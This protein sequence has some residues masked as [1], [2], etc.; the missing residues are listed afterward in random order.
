MSRLV[1]TSP[2]LVRQ[3]SSFGFTLIARGP[4]EWAWLYLFT[5]I[6]DWSTAGSF[7][8]LCPGERETE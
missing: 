1:F 8:D 2:T 7:R 3:L 4:A 6:D 5:C